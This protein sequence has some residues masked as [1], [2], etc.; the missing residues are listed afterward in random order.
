LLAQRWSKYMLCNDSTLDF[1]TVCG[2]HPCMG[3]QCRWASENMWNKHENTH[4]N[5]PLKMVGLS[6][7]YHDIS[8]AYMLR[9]QPSYKMLGEKTTCLW[10]SFVHGPSIHSSIAPRYWAAIC[11]HYLA[12]RCI[13]DGL[14]PWDEIIEPGFGIATPRRIDRYIYIN[15]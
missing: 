14:G 13:N 8:T 4:W 12:S 3:R 6:W 7:I 5:S 1:G 2:F 15:I 10:T 11:A 9:W